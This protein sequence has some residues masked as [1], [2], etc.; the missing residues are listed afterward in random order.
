MSNSSLEQLKARAQ[1]FKRGAIIPRKVLAVK[2]RKLQH[3][4][5]F[6]S[7]SWVLPGKEGYVVFL[8]S[9]PVTSAVIIGSGVLDVQGSRYHETGMTYFIGD[10]GSSPEEH[11]ERI[12][13]RLMP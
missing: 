5:R 6:G 11:L 4:L 8:H 2:Q 1:F 3:R 9:T 10:S 13:E 12:Q 7:D